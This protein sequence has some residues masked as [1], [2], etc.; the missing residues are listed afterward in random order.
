[1][2]A[3]GEPLDLEEPIRLEITEQLNL[4]L[5]DT[6]TIRDLYKKSHW[7]TADLLPASSALR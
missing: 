4:L 7:Q 3:I 6:M 5:A 2:I 1:V